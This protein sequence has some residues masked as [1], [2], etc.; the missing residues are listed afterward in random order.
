LRRQKEAL[1]GELG[2]LQQ[3]VAAL[4][5]SVATLTASQAGINAQLDATKVELTTILASYCDMLIKTLPKYKL[6]SE[7]VRLFH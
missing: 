6:T 3:E 7:T 5:S 4:K 1:E 2:G